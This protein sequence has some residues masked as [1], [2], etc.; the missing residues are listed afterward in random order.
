MYCSDKGESIRA[1]MKQAGFTTVRIWEQQMN[2][3]YKDGIDYFSA[4]GIT[5]CRFVMESPEYPEELK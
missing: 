2:M 3:L 4:I 1:M 5:V